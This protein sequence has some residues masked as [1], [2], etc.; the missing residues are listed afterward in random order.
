MSVDI[1]PS[2]ENQLPIGVNLAVASAIKF[3]DGAYKTAVDSEVA[4]ELRS[5]AAID[6]HTVSDHK[7][8]HA[9]KAYP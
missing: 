6:D 7:I 9:S 8:M 2:G 1:H 5:A 4:I 3:A